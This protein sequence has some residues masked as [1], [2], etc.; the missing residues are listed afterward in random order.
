MDWIK[1]K[2]A[3]LKP[4]ARDAALS[5]QSKLTK[6]PGSLGQ[7][8]AMAVWLAERQGSKAPAANKIWIGVFAADHGVMAQN[9]SAFPQ[10]V[11]GE[12]IKNFAA[13]GAAISVLAKSLGAKLEVINLG[14]VNDPGQIKGVDYAP[15]APQTANMVEGAAMT[16]AQLEQ[17]LL[18]GRDMAERAHQAQT[19][20]LICGDMGIGN[21][22]S[23]A[24]LACAYL[25]LSPEKLVGPG[26]GVDEAGIK[27][28][29]QIVRRAL[30]VN[31]ALCESPQGV[32]QALGGFEIAAMAGAM[33]RSAQMGQ[34][35]LVDGYIASTAALSAVRMNA[36]VLDWLHF[37][38]RSAEPG[39]VAILDA[40]NAKTVLDLGMCLGEASGA[41]VTVPLFRLACDLHNN[42][43]TFE[44]A[45][46]SEA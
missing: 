27:H 20:L 26:T 44:E 18:Q 3:A 38:H 34:C 29:A 5:R 13:G 45:G 12:M 43:A 28:K 46:V 33:I 2:S 31:Q 14:T 6:P 9:V 19:E 41:A 4:A 24:A 22:T 15:I 37:S 36:S 30:N 35:V 17:A 10:A 42:M 1:D 7:L 23:S 11:T 32:L 39:H 40:L 16:A 25:Q 21:T 8:E